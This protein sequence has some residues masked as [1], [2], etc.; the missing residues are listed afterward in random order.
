MTYKKLTRKY[1]ALEVLPQGR[2]FKKLS[3]IHKS[4]EALLFNLKGP[5]NLAEAN[6][7]F[8]LTGSKLPV[9][10]DGVKI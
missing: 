6:T 4:G 7:L 5:T 1:S 2:N 3:E 8:V 9:G 10:Q